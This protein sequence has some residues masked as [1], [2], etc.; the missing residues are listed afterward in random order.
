MSKRDNRDEIITKRIQEIHE[1]EEE[2][3]QKALIKLR[4]EMPPITKEEEDALI[5]SIEEYIIRE[6]E[7]LSIPHARCYIEAW[8][9][10]IDFLDETEKSVFKKCN[11]YMT[12]LKD[13]C[14]LYYNVSYDNERFAHKWRK[15]EISKFLKAFVK[16]WNGCHSKY[17]LNWEEAFPYRIRI[18]KKFGV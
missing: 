3:K 14:V 13:Y 16:T 2:K 18:K 11:S 10:D 15:T 12:W 5:E 6:R 17:V 4:V 1:R 8:D 7:E 9:D